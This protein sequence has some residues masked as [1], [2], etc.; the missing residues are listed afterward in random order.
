MSEHW[1]AAATRDKATGIH[2]FQMSSGR[3][4]A[5]EKRVTAGGEISAIRRQ[6]KV[7]QSSALN[8][9]RC[10]IYTDTSLL[11]KITYIDSQQFRSTIT[12]YGL[13]TS[14]NIPNCGQQ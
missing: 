9:Q 2:S 5:T 4:G 6:E 3:R 7:K 12:G 8:E 1:Q 14:S 13:C 11:V 10:G